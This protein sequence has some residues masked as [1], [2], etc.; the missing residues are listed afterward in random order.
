MEPCF[1]SGCIPPTLWRDYQKIKR[2]MGGN[3]ETLRDLQRW[4]RLHFLLNLFRNPSMCA[5]LPLRGPDSA[6]SSQ[7][8]HSVHSPA[9]GAV[10]M[11]DGAQARP[12]ESAY[13]LRSPSI[14]NFTSTQSSFWSWEMWTPSTILGQIWEP[15]FKASPPLSP[16][17][18]PSYFRASALGLSSSQSAQGSDLS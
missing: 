4:P 11:M 9:M 7:D 12:V 15:R 5:V 10:K 17:S 1:N 13:F 2:E 8:R 18:E 16:E 6:E 3:L 14:F